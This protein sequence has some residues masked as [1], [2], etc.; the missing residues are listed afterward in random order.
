MEGGASKRSIRPSDPPFTV[1]DGPAPIAA[2]LG[3]TFGCNR[4]Y[5][6]CTSS[7]RVLQY[8]CRFSRQALSAAT[9]ARALASQSQAK[10]REFTAQSMAVP[11]SEISYCRR[12]TSVD[13]SAMR[14]LSRACS[15][16]LWRSSDLRRSTLA[17]NSPIVSL[18]P[19]LLPSCRDA[20]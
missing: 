7:C 8:A 12:L 4:S 20:S 16:H 10:E 11:R 9:Q 18:L 19:L 15:L 13:S 5:N 14:Q 6:T 2:T 1:P 17:S 3:G